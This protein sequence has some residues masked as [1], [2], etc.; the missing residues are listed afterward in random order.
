M[1]RELDMTPKAYLME[2]RMLRAEH[3]LRTN[4]KLNVSEVAYKCG[5]SEPKYFSRC[6]KK[7]FGKTPSDF[8]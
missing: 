4:N 2:Q 5:F 8:R 7:R 6:F 3:L 1:K